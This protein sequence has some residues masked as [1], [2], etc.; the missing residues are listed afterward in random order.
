MGSEQTVPTEVSMA[1]TLRHIADDHPCCAGYLLDAAARIEALER[2]LAEIAE[3]KGR[4]SRDPLTH[5]SNTVEDMKAIAV[6]ALAQ[7]KPVCECVPGH[8]CE[9]HVD[10]EKW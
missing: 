10:R 3:G 4:F 1:D 9:L 8:L 6:A 7:E 5:A 2:A